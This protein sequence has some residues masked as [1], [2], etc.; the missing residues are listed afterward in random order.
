MPGGCAGEDA[1]WLSG[2]GLGALTV[3]YGG[4]RWKNNG[5]LSTDIFRG[6]CFTTNLHELRTD[7]ISAARD[8]DFIDTK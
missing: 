3:E 2:A 6:S 8:L 4:D 7:A 5:I 1:K